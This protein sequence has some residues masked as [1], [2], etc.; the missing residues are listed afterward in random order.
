MRVLIRKLTRR[1][2]EGTAHQDRQVEVPEVRIGRGTDQEVQIGDL[3]VALNHAVIRPAG[4]GRLE[5]A[6]VGSGGFLINGRWQQHGRLKVGDS[7]EIGNVTIGLIQPPEGAD[8]A[9]EVQAVA[10]SAGAGDGGRAVPERTV[11]AGGAVSKRFWSWVFFIGILG[12]FLGL[13]VAGFFNPPVQELLRASPLP[14]DHV[15]NTGPLVTAHTYFAGDC[16]ACHQQP[17]VR[18]SDQACAACHAD[19]PDHGLSPDRSSP[20]ARAVNC[21]SCHRDHNGDHGM[22]ATDQRLC[23]DCHSEQ[24]MAAVPIPEMLPAGDFGTAH[25]QFR[26]TLVDFDGTASP[27]VRRVAVDDPAARETA[28][29]K[30][31]QDAHLDPAGLQSPRGEIVLQCA[32]CH[33]PE[34]GGG[35]MAPIQMELH[36]QGCHGLELDPNYPQR[37]VPHGKPE[38]ILYL[39]SEYFSRLAVEG[40]YWVRGQPAVSFDT[41]AEAREWAHRQALTAAGRMFEDRACGTCHQ[42]DRHDTVDGPRWVVRPAQLTNHWFPA[43]RFPHSKHRSMDC[44]SCHA[45]ETSSSSEDVLMPGIETCRECHGGQTKQANRIA[46]TCVSCHGFHSHPHPDRTA[47]LGVDSGLLKVRGDEA[48]E[49]ETPRR[50]RPGQR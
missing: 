43:A 45:A 19:M 38:E 33:Q 24:A 22:I 44:V 14:S 29:L 39:V 1:G 35:L 23:S 42:V 9:V 37:S 2:K 3:R 4:G 26:V 28:T 30:F 7:V 46:S 17:F 32:D 8:L 13:P 48:P 50:R 20:G 36:C 21:A 15:W 34:P 49:T 40:A 27:P 10:P 25:S 47:V 41:T 6:A 11:L 5:I 18:V 16:Q 31:P 12:L